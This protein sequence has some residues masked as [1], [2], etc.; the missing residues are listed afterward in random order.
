[1][2]EGLERN[3]KNAFI[4]YFER[5]AKGAFDFVYKGQDLFKRTLKPSDPPQKI[6]RSIS[7]K[8]VY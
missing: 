1:M 3:K 2:T 5:M 6:V 8:H 7:T 4:E